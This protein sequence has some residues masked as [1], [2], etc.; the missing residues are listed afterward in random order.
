MCRS[1][2]NS[3][4]SSECSARNASRSAAR[5]L[6]AMLTIPVRAESVVRELAHQ[7]VHHAGQIP[8]PRVDGPL[9]L[10]RGTV[11]EHLEGHGQ[12]LEAAQPQGYRLEFAQELV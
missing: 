11:L 3:M 7:G 8:R 2:R 4:S 6:P 12:F 5:S 1:R 9:P 10:V